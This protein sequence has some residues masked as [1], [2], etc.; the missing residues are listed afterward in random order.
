MTTFA[1]F[2]FR[3]ILQEFKSVLNQKDLTAEIANRTSDV[4]G[5]QTQI[6]TANTNISNEIEN[7]QNADIVLQNNINTIKQFITYK[8]TDKASGLSYSQAHPG[9]FVWWKE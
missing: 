7:R 9:V 5:L 8:A 1:K 6:D 3:S 4:S 2:L